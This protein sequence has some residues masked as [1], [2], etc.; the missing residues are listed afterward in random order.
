MEVIGYS[1]KIF[2][3]IEKEELGMSQIS[4]EIHLVSFLVNRIQTFKN[5]ILKDSEKNNSLTMDKYLKEILRNIS[6]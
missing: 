5:V 3:K 6:K 4:N 1:V 2:T